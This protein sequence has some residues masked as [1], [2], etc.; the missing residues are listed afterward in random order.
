MRRPIM[1]TI[2]TITG[3]TAIVIGWAHQN[4]TAVRLEKVKDRATCRPAPFA[5]A[6]CRASAD[7]KTSAR[8]TGSL[9]IIVDSVQKRTENWIKGPRILSHSI[10]RKSETNSEAAPQVVFDRIAL[11]GQHARNQGFACHA[12]ISLR[13]G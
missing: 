13:I 11:E 7:T 2:L 1:L 9:A 6:H 8:H 4:A 12:S 5:A 3:A 10:K